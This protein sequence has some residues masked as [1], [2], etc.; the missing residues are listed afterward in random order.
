MYR[1]RS[2]RSR[3]IV[4][5]STAAAVLAVASLLIVS[6]A[7]I[8]G[9]LPTAVTAFGMACSAY[10]CTIISERIEDSPTRRG[11]AR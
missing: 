7:A 6:V 2:A 11:G 3:A 9:H 4:R 10:V 8:I 1:S 5:W